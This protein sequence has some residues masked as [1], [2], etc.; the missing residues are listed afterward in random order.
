MLIYL[1]V[2]IN[3]INFLYETT[4]DQVQSIQPAL[5]VLGPTAALQL[6]HCVHVELIIVGDFLEL[7]DVPDGVNDYPRGPY[8]V[9]YLRFTVGL[10]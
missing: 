4:Q 1:G 5:A 7:F 2:Q 3:N 10:C 8:H 9:L 6:L